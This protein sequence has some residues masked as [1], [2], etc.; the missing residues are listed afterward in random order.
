MTAAIWSVRSALETAGNEIDAAPDD[1]QA[2]H[3]RALIV[4][5]IV[6]QACTDILRRITRAYGPYPLAMDGAIA[7]RI[8]E[9]DLY[10]RQSHAERDLE[11]LGSITLIQR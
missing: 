2:A 5:H 3:Q 8:H 11:V 1:A 10:V 4:R 7:R 9:L 6:E